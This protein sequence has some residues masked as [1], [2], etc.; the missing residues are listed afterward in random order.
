MNRRVLYIADQH[1]RGAQLEK[2]ADTVHM[3]VSTVE[4]SFDDE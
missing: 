1:V 2:I 4:V 3:N